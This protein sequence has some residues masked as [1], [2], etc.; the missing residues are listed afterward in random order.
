MIE[1]ELKGQDPPNVV[2]GASSDPTAKRKRAVLQATQICV[3]ESLYKNNTQNTIAVDF[4]ITMTGTQ[5]IEF[6]M[7][8]MQPD[9]GSPARR[10][11]TYACSLPLPDMCTCRR[12]LMP[13]MYGL[14]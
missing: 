6:R 8:C 4:G 14:F 9:L 2:A 3:V 5:D 13:S 12:T 11:L 7:S 10:D 1:Y